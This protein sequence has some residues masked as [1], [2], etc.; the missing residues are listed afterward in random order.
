MAAKKRR[1]ARP[2]LSRGRSKSGKLVTGDSKAGASVD[3]RAPVAEPAAPPVENG[4][5]RFPVVGIGA[6]AGGLHALRQFFE[7]MPVDNGMAF[8]VIPHLDPTHESLMVELLGKQTP[9]PVVEAAEGVST[10]P[11]RVYVIPPNKY[12]AIRRRVLHL[13]GPI[14]RHG[15]TTSIDFFLRALA[16]DQ[17]EQAIGII[18]SGTSTHGTL[19]IKDIKAHGGMAMVQD[20]GTA[21]Y[22]QMPQSAIATGLIDFILPV[23]KMPAALLEYIRQPYIFANPADRAAGVDVDQ[24]TQIVALLRA[25][26]RYDFRCYRKSMLQRR[27]ERRMGLNRIEQISDYVAFLRDQ[28]DELKQLTRDLLISVTQFFRDPDAFRALADE[29]IPDLVR[30]TNPDSP[31]RVWIPACATGEEAYSIAILLLEQFSAARKESRIQVFATDVDEAALAIARQ[32]RY[33]ESITAD[34]S[35]ERLERFFSPVE[36]N[37]FQ[38]HKELREAVAFSS[39]NL[40]RDAPFSRMDLI[41]CRNVLIYLEPEVQHRLIP[42]FHFALNEGGFLLLGSSE[43]IGR[44]TDLFEPVSKKWRIYRRSGHARPH[45]FDFPIMAEEK[46]RGRISPHVEPQTAVSA[47]FEELTERSLLAEYAPAA[48]LVTSAGQILYFHGPTMLYLDQPTGEPT[49]DL[50]RM[51]RDGLRAKLRTAMHKALH[52]N[53]PVELADVKIKRNGTSHLVQAVVR[54]LQTPKA[55]EP[56]LLV[57]FRDLAEVEPPQARTV[58]VSEE[59]V[60]RHLESELKTAREE[61]QG[62]VDEFESLTEEQKAGHEPSR[63][64]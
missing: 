42:L 10:E 13:T 46:R 36:G 47:N 41:N 17:Q 50:F 9:M 4:D 6:S 3:R 59:S 38:V 5:H 63:R 8:V 57:T 7:K 28:P 32:G 23:E 29:V 30:R 11:N 15:P 48:V 16:E 24:L 51:A 53:G 21:E 25:R 14:E 33:P 19:G 37:S 31:L 54:P 26:V 34:V 2:K 64:K 61:L 58:D 12:L 56:L 55:P 44:H 45:W 35:R 40:L 60:V 27:V 49:R 22:D 20:P 39:Q 18:L 1:A 43:T 62:T 52:Q